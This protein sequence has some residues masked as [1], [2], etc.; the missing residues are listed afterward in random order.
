MAITP[1]SAPSTATNMAGHQRRAAQH[2]PAPFHDAHDA[3]PS[4]RAEVGR[5]RERHVPGLGRPQ[6]RVGQR[7]FAAALQAGGQPQQRRLVQTAD[8][9]DRGHA[10]PALGQRAGLV[11]HQGVDTSQPLERLG[12]TEQHAGVRAAANADHDR[13]RGRQ[14]QG[15]GAGDDQHRDRRDQRIS[16]PWL[17]SDHRPRRAGEHRHRD[18]RRR[19]PAGDYVR[20]PLDR[21]AAALR[22]GHH[23]HDAREQGLA[24]HLLGPHHERAGAVDRAGDHLGARLAAHR[25]RL[26]GDQRLVEGGAALQHL[27]VHRHLLAWPD[28]QA[29]ADPDPVQRHFLVRPVRPD[30]PGG[31][32]REA[33]QRLDRAGGLRPGA[34][35]QHLAEQRQ[36]GDHGRG[37]EVDR[38]G[39]VHV[40]ERSRECA[41]RGNGH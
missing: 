29:V 2:D 15:A 23:L 5:L 12:V 33:E 36:H 16:Q 31:L 35:L 24:P 10:R 34:Q 9:L 27:A 13:H 22:F 11:D 28:A 1:A 40:P 14:P 17:R 19:E 20:H 4:R 37:L 26:A 39:A 18:H 3:A 7:M 25:H 41:R 32:R 6:D 8:R 30:A 38:N 21:C